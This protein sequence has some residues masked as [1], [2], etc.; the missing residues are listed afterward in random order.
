[1]FTH[2]TVMP[3]SLVKASS[4]AL[5][6][7]SEARATVMVTPLVWVEASLLW[8]LLL[9]PPQAVASSPRLASATSRRVRCPEVRR[10]VFRIRCASVS[11]LHWT[12]WRSRRQVE[13][14][15]LCKLPPDE[16]RDRE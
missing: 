12:D 16:L 1:M 6:G 9:P 7:E 3:V 2:L 11:V 15:Q 4:A 13:A 8:L 10:R 5:G 14:A